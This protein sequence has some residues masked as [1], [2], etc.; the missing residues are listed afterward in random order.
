MSLDHPDTRLAK[1]MLK[2]SHEV[3]HAKLRV[4]RYHAGSVTELLY[5]IF[6]GIVLLDFL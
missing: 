3:T 5:T 6:R 1:G 2:D 4:W